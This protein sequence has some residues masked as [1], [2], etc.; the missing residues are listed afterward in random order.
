LEKISQ[1]QQTRLAVAKFHRPPNRS[2][3]QTH[4]PAQLPG[5]KK[6]SATNFRAASYRANPA[7][8]CHLL[9]IFRQD[10]GRTRGSRLSGGVRNY[11]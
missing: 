3:F 8:N 4:S 9:H 2:S 5:L 1:A 6:L 7:S 11:L 10:N